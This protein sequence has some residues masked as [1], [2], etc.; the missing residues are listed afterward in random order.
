MP[1]VFIARQPI[2][3]RKLEVVGYELLFRS[4]HVDH[5][6][7]V[8]P[9]EAT[10]T[11]VLNSFTEIGL[12]RIVGDKTAWVNVSRDFLV[13]GLAQAIPPGL[14]GIEVVA[15][16]VLDERSI[17][18]LREL[19]AQ[20]YSLALDDFRHRPEVAPLLELVDVVKLDLA[21]LGH[22]GLTASIARL[23]A[24]DVALLAEKVETRS[25]HEFCAGTGCD[26]FQGYFFC[27]PVLLS[28]RGIGVNRL[29]LLRV[30]ANLHDPT[31]EL[32]D[33]EELI[34][35]D[36][37]LS[38]RLLRYINSAFFGL[39]GEVRSIGQ[40]L[41]L[42]GLENVR[43]WATLSILADLNDAPRELTITALVRARFCERAGEQL[44]LANP[45]ELFTL[46]MFS[47]IDAMMDAPMPDVL[48]SLPFPADMREALINHRGEKGLLLECVATLETG[49]LDRARTIVSRAS[50]LYTE[51]LIWAN[52]AADSLFSE[53]GAAAA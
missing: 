15:D 39:R 45:G 27:R 53:I 37:A 4:G 8:D 13:E 3:N 24:Y 20:G 43:R 33:I 7:V 30:V 31:V 38:F 34:S 28:D 25:D 16:D 50:E 19:K 18:A 5:A 29:A 2:F 42:L 40:A 49:E 51:S 46:G 9:E 32:S 11:V 17:A 35:K 23:S 21:A 36:V 6:L 48:A 14:V 22:D 12:D 41:A 10:A 44:G 47:V 1:D 52:G 26:L